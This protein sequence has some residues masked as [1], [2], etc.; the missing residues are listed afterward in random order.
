MIRHVQSSL[1]VREEVD[2]I[3]SHCRN[4]RGPIRWFRLGVWA[5]ALVL[6][7]LASGGGVR[8]EPPVATGARLGG[9]VERT[10]FVTDLTRPVGFSVSVL[11]DPF[12]VIIDLPEVNFQLPP[13]LGGIGR[14]LVS[15][16]RY[17]LFDAGK[18]R[19][20]LDANGPVLIHKSFL[21][22]PQN[23]QPARLVVDLV[24]TDRSTFFKIHNLV[25]RDT[26]VPASQ[27]VKPR[28][29]AQV[30]VPKPNP[31]RT[32]PKRN[33]Q[34]ALL[35]PQAVPKAKPRKRIV[36]I[37]PGHG[38][39][40]PGAVGRRGTAEKNV[41]L[42]FS[43]ILRR[44]LEAT[45]K[46]KVYM[47][48]STD[49]F[50]KL[51]DRV[52]FAREHDADLF[53]AVHADAILRRKNQVRGATVY[54]LSSRA[55]DK[56]AAALA[57]RENKA[58]L[59]AGVDLAVQNDDVTGILIDLAQRATN[60]SSV[61][62]AGILVKSLGT[63]TRVTRVPHRQAGF[64]VLKAPDIPSVLLELGYISNFRDEKLLVSDA[65]RQKVS[66]AVVK[67]VIRYFKTQQALGG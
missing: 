28:P 20:V 16:Y 58:D 34:T 10:R 57:A 36:I 2:Q 51:R 4:G 12:R 49:K 26:P 33:I 8:A 35:R 67:A 30:P 50:I 22:K 60:K 31:K 55:S 62:F 47:T 13:G 64:R 53:I 56:E 42:A 66:A 17:G 40:D 32:K 54:T 19:I 44:K 23:N 1:E 37:D 39:V 18:S 61:A 38:G 48:R 25:D 27:T 24:K 9:D 45:G 63:A 21:L 59:I 7:C 5:L 41:V 11:P 6:F 15:A 65:W 43:K 3:Q 29:L 46:F 14:G 52:K